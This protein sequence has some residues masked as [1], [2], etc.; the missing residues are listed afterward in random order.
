[1]LKR[2]FDLLCASVG[3]LVLSPLFLVI[4]IWI[5]CDSRGSVFF[6]QIRV[7]IKETPFKIIKFRSMKTD[8]EKSDVQVT[9]LDDNRITRCGRWIRKFKIDELPQLINVLRGEMSLVGPR[10]EV[11]KY[12]RYYSENNRKIALSVKP[13]ITDISS[14]KY[15]NENDLLMSSN[16]PEKMYIENVL[17]EKI[18]YVVEY[19]HKQSFMLDLQL[20]IKTV[21]F[22]LFDTSNKQSAK[23]L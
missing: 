22:I 11:P 1:M 19:V 10:P 3:L 18:K 16:D 7:G 2:A 23:K 21:L 8:A 4:A 6:R 13:G 17:P 14:L 5:K 9:T 20:I 15:R 12:L